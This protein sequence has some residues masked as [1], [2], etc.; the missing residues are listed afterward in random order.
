MPIGHPWVD[1]TCLYSRI[2]FFF[3]VWLLAKLLFLSG[4]CVRLASSVCQNSMRGRA[5]E[6]VEEREEKENLFKNSGKP[7]S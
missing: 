4:E 2:S 5:E 3:S 6:A 7:T 1:S